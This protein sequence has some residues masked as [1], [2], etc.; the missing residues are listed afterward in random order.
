MIF[1][2]NRFNLIIM[3][4]FINELFNYLKLRNNQLNFIERLFNIIFASLGCTLFFENT[5]Y[6]RMLG[7]YIL[8]SEVILSPFF[9]F[10]NNIINYFFL[11][12]LTLNA[13]YLFFANPQV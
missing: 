10:Y 11:I 8:I 9:P 3:N 7:L 6:L 5:H 12:I 1:K 4:N 13:Y 2:W